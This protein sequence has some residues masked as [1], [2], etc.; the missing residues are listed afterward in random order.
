MQ[1][2]TRPPWCRDPRLSPPR[3]PRRCASASRG[4]SAA[5]APPLRALLALLAVA[6]ALVA[7]GC[8]GTP[9]DAATPATTVPDGFV[10][11]ELAVGSNATVPATLPTP[12]NFV[13]PDTRNVRLA[14]LIARPRNVIDHNEPT[15]P[16]NTG[17]AKLKGRVFDP[18]GHPIEG[19]TVRLQ[20]FVSEDNGILDIGTN[21]D[22]AWHAEELPGGRYRIR[23]WI[24]PA[25]ATVEPK[26]LFLLGDHGEG[27]VDVALEKHD[28]ISVIGA[29]DEAEPH[30]GQITTFRGLVAQE[31]VDDNGVVVGVGIPNAQVQLSPTDGGL[32]IIGTDV[33]T[34]NPDG[35]VLFAVACLTT[36]EHSVIIDSSGKQLAIGLPVCLEGSVDNLPPDTPEFA[37]DDTFTVPFDGPLPPGTYVAT[38]PGN[39]GTSYQE[40][41]DTWVNNVSLARTLTFANPT[42]HLE[43]IP[44]SKPCTF[45]RTK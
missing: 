21:K 15:L 14:P 42:R 30:V 40:F 2:V 17:T 24:K 3:A 45:K 8:A 1:Y 25:L 19:A 33:G 26:Q 44:G 31:S 23:A 37:V 20:R 12:E 29:L 5:V 28:G 22:G 18:E 4:P 13:I 7:V 34:T 35:F 38:T 16:M 10:P 39:C 32:K 11:P 41:T 36:G 6:V 9:D 43:P 27:E